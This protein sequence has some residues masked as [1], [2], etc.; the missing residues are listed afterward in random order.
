MSTTMQDLGID[1]LSVE[2]RVALA[3]EIWDSVTQDLQSEPLTPAQRQELEHRL[4]DSLAFSVPFSPKK[5]GNGYQK[6]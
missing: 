3:Q 6:I 4:A 1:L 5:W 2:D